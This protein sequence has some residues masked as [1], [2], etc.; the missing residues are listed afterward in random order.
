MK[1]STPFLSVL[2][3]TIS[4]RKNEA[5]K[6]FCDLERRAHG[7]PVEILML[8]DNRAANMGDKRNMLL[9]AARGNYITFIDDDD[10]FAPNYFSEVLPKLDAGVDVISYNQI[11]SVDGATSEVHCQL[12]NENDI[13]RPSGITLRKPWFW[14]V[15]RAGL[16]KNYAVPNTYTKDGQTFYE[17]E[18]WLRHLWVEAKSEI[19]INKILHFY[20]FSTAKTT[21]Q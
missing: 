11:A 5:E 1:K 15:W 18:L 17:D 20:N 10:S 7:L 12:K 6:L 3:P 21:L 9:R 2:I 16:A 4:G 8:R 14:C 19:V 13:F